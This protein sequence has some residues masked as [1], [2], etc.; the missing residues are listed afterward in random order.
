MMH[1][2]DGGETS[3]GNTLLLCS[4]HHRLLHEGGYSIHKNFEGDWYFRNSNGRI[5]PGTAVLET[6]HDYIHK[7]NQEISYDST[8]RSIGIGSDA[9]RDAFADDDW[10]GEPKVGSGISKVIL[11]SIGTRNLSKHRRLVRFQTE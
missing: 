4:R 6:T 2:A 7:A 10:V 9:S 11:D 1:W 8:N 5:L 3:S